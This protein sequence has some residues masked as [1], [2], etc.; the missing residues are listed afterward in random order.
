MF[1]KELWTSYKGRLLGVA[2]AVFLIIIYLI[3]G[4]WNMMFCALI[5]FIGYTAGKYKDLDQ[6]SLIPWKE[7]RDW[8][9]S[10][11]RPFR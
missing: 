3:S 8:L 6:G 2:A 4:F 1:W 11:W 9:F 10:K 7:I 5:L